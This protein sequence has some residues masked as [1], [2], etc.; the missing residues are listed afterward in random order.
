MTKF[1][2]EAYVFKDFHDRMFRQNRELEREQ[3]KSDPLFHGPVGRRVVD[4]LGGPFLAPV[5]WT[6]HAIYLGGVIGAVTA[7]FAPE[8]YE[9]AAKP[10]FGIVGIDPPGEDDVSGVVTAG[11]LTLMLSVFLGH[12]KAQ[13]EALITE[14]RLQ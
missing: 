12:L 2:P 9:A 5:R 13:R 10:L 1:G 8:A 14:G 11:F 6:L 7:M 4:V 3:K